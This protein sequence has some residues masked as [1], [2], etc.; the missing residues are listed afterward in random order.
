MIINTNSKRVR[1]VDEKKSKILCIDK[2][3]HHFEI[4]FDYSEM[5]RL[6]NIGYFVYVINEEGIF[7]FTANSEFDGFD[8]TKITKK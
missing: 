1:L 7:F 2:I 4:S 3:G 6:K 8:F 5:V